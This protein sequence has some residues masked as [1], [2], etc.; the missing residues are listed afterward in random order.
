MS[1]K[2]RKV[3]LAAAR[4]SK[5]LK[6]RNATNEA[7]LTIIDSDNDNELSDYHDSD[8]NWHNDKLENDLD[9]ISQTV[10]DV[11]IENAKDPSAFTNNRP[12]VYIGNS[13][14]TQRHKNS[15]NK[16]AAVGTFKLDSFFPTLQSHQQ[17]SHQ[18]TK[19]LT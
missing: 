5:A 10:F 19:E 6:A 7:W 13:E 16:I 2:K 1:P 11:M 9:L 3:Q 8:D 18:F 14:R 12:S 15:A 4:N 17:I